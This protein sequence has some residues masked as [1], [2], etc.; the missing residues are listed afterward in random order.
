MN[1]SLGLLCLGFDDLDL[2][3]FKIDY[4]MVGCF[5][6]G[7]CWVLGAGDALG[8]FRGRPHFR[9]G[10]GLALGLEFVT[11]VDFRSRF[12]IS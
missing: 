4:G 3:F 9:F 6:D 7:D 1:D 8:Y 10:A 2:A 12:S 5:E 11:F